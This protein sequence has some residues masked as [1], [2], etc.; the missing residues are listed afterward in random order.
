[1]LNQYSQVWR[2]ARPCIKSFPIFFIYAALNLKGMAPLSLF[3]HGWP[4]VWT[5]RL[6]RSESA[7]LSL[8]VDRGSLLH[9]LC[10]TEA[11]DWSPW[12]HKKLTDWSSESRRRWR[13]LCF[14]LHY[15]K[16][17]IR[18]KRQWWSS[19]HQGWS[20]FCGSWFEEQFVQP[21]PPAAARFMQTS[22]LTWADT[23]HVLPAP[24][25]RLPS[26]HQST[27]EMFYSA[28][29]HGCLPPGC[30]HSGKKKEGRVCIRGLRNGG[31]DLLHVFVTC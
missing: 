22:S 28:H 13:T 5:R 25:R 24:G 2:C 1:M 20:T 10:V 21:S 27:C 3:P 14:L 19:Y 8:T 16:D 12:W 6:S 26:R 18:P 15:C 30:L 23:G 31:Q 4:P 11:S 17:S 7:S 9:L 29:L